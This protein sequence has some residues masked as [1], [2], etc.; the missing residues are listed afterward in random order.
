[1]AEHKTTTVG[2]SREAHRKLRTMSDKTGIKGFRIVSDAVERAYEL[3]KA[4]ARKGEV[5]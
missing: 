4:K 5:K 3:W 2:I 1:M